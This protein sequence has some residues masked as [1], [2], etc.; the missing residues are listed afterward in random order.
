MHP[1]SIMA[2]ID[3]EKRTRNG[4][5]HA[6]GFYLY[7]PWI[8]EDVVGRVININGGA[9]QRHQ[10]LR[11]I[12]FALR[13]LAVGARQDTEKLDLAAFIIINLRI[14]ANTID[15]AACAW[16]KRDYWVKADQFRMQWRW[17]DRMI[18]AMEAALP[19]KDWQSLANL[20]AELAG[21]LG[22]AEPPK[23]TPAIPPWEGAWNKHN[24]KK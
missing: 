10:A 8:L 3:L 17:L 22:S 13:M 16:E 15:Q 4:K 9:K 14:I 6:P 12:A 5:S 1:R 23:R 19:Q 7:T 24:L 18:P 20:A 2:S 11:M 21:K